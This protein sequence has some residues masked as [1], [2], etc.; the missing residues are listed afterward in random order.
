MTKHHAY[1]NPYFASPEFQNSHERAVERSIE[2]KVRY[3]WNKISRIWKRS[4]IMPK[5]ISDTEYYNKN[6]EYPF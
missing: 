3:I 1:F 2:S 4:T 5:E 6:K